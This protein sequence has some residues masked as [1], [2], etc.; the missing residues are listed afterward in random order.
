[1]ESK[2]YSVLEAL[3][4]RPKNPAGEKAAPDGGNSQHTAKQKKCD[5]QCVDCFLLFCEEP[6]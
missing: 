1:M 3:D 4:I 5:H 2:L 6:A